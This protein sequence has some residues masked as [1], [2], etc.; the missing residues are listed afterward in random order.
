MKKSYENVKLQIICTFEED[1]ITTS[2]EESNDNI[3]P[4]PDFPEFP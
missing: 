3:E 4:M 1:V 2:S